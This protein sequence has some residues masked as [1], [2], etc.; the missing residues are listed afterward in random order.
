VVPELG[1]GGVC[2]QWNMREYAAAYVLCP[3]LQLSPHPTWANLPRQ[4]YQHHTHYYKKQLQIKEPN[5]WV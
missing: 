5:T 1:T 2:A 3:N 4:Q